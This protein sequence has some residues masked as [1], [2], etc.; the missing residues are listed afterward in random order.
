MVVD[1]PALT[2]V[3]VGSGDGQQNVPAA[4][5]AWKS[6]SKK[7]GERYAPVPKDLSNQ[8][9]PE[10][11]NVWSN[12]APSQKKRKLLQQ[13]LK[14]FFIT[15][16]KG[17]RDVA[18]GDDITNKDIG[19]STDI[20]RILVVKLISVGFP[21]GTVMCYLEIQDRNFVPCFHTSRAIDS[22]S[23]NIFFPNS[24][25]AILLQT[26]SQTQAKGSKGK[27]E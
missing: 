23:L 3:R 4:A 6:T 17:N 20:R 27:R 18:N 11:S 9:D 19:G 1:E 2:G 25:Q 12:A 13:S 21:F 22:Q 5:S 7:T 8:K 26:L 24:S 15:S 16:D 14:T 10:S